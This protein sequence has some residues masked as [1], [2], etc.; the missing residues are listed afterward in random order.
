MSRGDL[1]VKV[2]RLQNESKQCIRKVGASE[3]KEIWRKSLIQSP[4]AHG[5]IY[6]LSIAIDAGML[7]PSK[8]AKT[9]C[10]ASAL[11]VSSLFNSISLST[12]KSIHPSCPCSCFLTKSWRYYLL[13][14]RSESISMVTKVIY[15][16]HKFD[17][18]MFNSFPFPTGLTLMYD[19]AYKIICDLAYF[20]ILIFH[21]LP[22]SL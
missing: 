2:D 19:L 21:R 12:H 18:N 3:R 8:R 22:F 13:N 5:G 4:P 6:L 11:L 10:A 16:K 1:S 7:E 9:K 14:F 20:S 15:Q 17:L